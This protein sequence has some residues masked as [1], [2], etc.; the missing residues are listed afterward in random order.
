VKGDCK[1]SYVN[2][3]PSKVNL[4]EGNIEVGEGVS[5]KRVGKNMEDKGLKQCNVIFILSPW[6]SIQDKIS[7][8]SLEAKFG[9]ERGLSKVR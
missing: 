8:I 1:E 9:W 6:V 2:K 5:S 7:L 4:Q 3:H